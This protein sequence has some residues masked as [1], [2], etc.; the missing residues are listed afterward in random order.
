MWRTVR[1]MQAPTE[2]GAFDADHS[3]PYLVKPDGVEFGEV[4]LAENLVTEERV[5]L[6]KLATEKPRAAAGSG[7]HGS[8]AAASNNR[9]TSLILRRSERRCR[10]GLP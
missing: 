2:D 6:E 8:V 9:A 4:S 10:N 5:L 1:A 7:Q 3:V